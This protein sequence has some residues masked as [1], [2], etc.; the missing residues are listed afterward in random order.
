MRI[1]IKNATM[2][3]AVPKQ[4]IVRLAADPDDVTAVMSDVFGA[5]KGQKVNVIIQGVEPE[6]QEELWKLPPVAP[7]QDDRHLLAGGAVGCDCGGPPGMH[8]P[9]CPHVFGREG[10]GGEDP[11]DDRP[12]E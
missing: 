2:S 4:V 11:G 6:G 9:D 1:E 5:A 7:A 12:T 3:F 8:A 10:D